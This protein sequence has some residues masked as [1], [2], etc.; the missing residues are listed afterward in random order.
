[1]VANKMDLAA[2]RGKMGAR[3]FYC[4]MFPVGLVPRYFKFRDW[5]EMPPELRA[6]RKLTDRRVPEIARYILEHE[7]DWVF[8]S[9][10]ASFNADAEFIE[11]EIDPNIGILRM[12]LDADFLIN[13]GQHRKAAIEQ[14][15][16]D[17]RMLE[18]Q[19]ISVVMFPEENLER[20]QQIFSDLNRTVHK[21]S[22]S[23]DILYDHRDPMNRIAIAVA[24]AV[25]VFQGRVEKDRVSVAQRST[26][27][28]ALS[29]LYDANVALLGKLKEDE[30]DDDAEAA[31][32]ERAIAY[33]SAIT[34][35]IPEWTNVRD[36][37]Q[38]P[39]E[40]RAEYIHAHA[41]AF[42]ALGAAGKGL[43]EKYPDE[44][45]WRARLGHLSE[46]DW[47]KTNPEWQGICMLGSDIITRRQTREATSKYIQW[48]LGVLDEKPSRVLDVE[49]VT[50]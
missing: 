3:D 9:L 23:L 43:I 27:F 41:V 15:L 22:R 47:R 25:P 34:D 29:A 40:V 30:A 28:V 50:A 21:T 49:P 11:S 48:K 35:N 32:E 4:V 44:V 7:D 20:N 12:P 39:P 14:A 17:N 19:T 45:S 37:D 2:I 31:F 38:K 36:G 42:W 5:A 46:I 8:S 33:W 6:Q 26:K 24:D 18:K 1:M 16:K 10:T 13:D